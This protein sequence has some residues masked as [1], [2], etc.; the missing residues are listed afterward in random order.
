MES[1]SGENERKDKDMGPAEA[2]SY[3]PG[4][5]SDGPTPVVRE[6]EGGV[7]LGLQQRQ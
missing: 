6:G 4:Y 3:G 7:K 2:G 1:A 5:F